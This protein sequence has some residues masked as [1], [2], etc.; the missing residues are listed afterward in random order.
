MQDHL[1]NI[2]WFN[3]E[4]PLN[5]SHIYV[6]LS[7]CHL[8]IVFKPSRFYKGDQCHRHHFIILPC[9]RRWLWKGYQF[10]RSYNLAALKTEAVWEMTS[11]CRVIFPEAL[12]MQIVGCC[13]DLLATPVT[14]TILTGKQTSSMFSL[15]L[16]LS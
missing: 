14:S 12:K 7:F 9:F 6:C 16:T 13:S 15:F 3:L 4:C 8:V 1:I 2:N 11:W 5:E 10:P